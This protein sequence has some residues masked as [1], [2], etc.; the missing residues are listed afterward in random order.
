MKPPALFLCILFICTA[1]GLTGCARLVRPPLDDAAARQRIIQWSE[2]NQELTAIKGLMHIQIQ[3]RGDRMGGRV[4]WAAVLPDRLRL[5][6]LNPLGQPLVSL[7]GDGR[8]ITLYSFADKQ[9]HHFPQTPRALERLTRIPIGIEDL[10]VILAG[11]PPLPDHV[12]ARTVSPNRCGVAL[13]SRWHLPVAEL[14]SDN[15]DRLDAMVIYDRN[16]DLQYHIQWLQ[17]QKVAAHTLPREIRLTSGAGDSVA[18]TMERV[19]IDA[20]MPPETFVVAP[21]Q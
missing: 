5:E 15:C 2:N 14:Q 18:L 1:A 20:P 10:I 9:F 12:A 17:W 16:G 6:W 19:W 13:E 4:A 21:P 8:A 3:A 7:A 11:R